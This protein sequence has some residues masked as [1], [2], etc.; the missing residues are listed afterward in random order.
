MK[1]SVYGIV[2]G[3]G[4]RPTV[5]RVAKAMGLKGFVLNNGSNVEI[6][7][8]RDA[9]EFLKK[10][11]EALPALARIDRADLEDV[12]EDLADFTI[13]QSREGKRVS[14][15]PTDTAICSQC[16]KDL[17]TPRDKR[18]MFPFTNCT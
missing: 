2:Q 18:H 11:K 4:F 5:Y 17:D 3:V 7:V 15:L 9:E 1:I 14:L 6:H 10:L 13:A 16:A 12:R 8:D